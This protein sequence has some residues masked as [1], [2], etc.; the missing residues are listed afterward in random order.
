MLNEQI[1]DGGIPWKNRSRQKRCHDVKSGWNSI[2][3][4]EIFNFDSLD[5]GRWLKEFKTR[6]NCMPWTLCLS[7]FPRS[8]VP[9]YLVY[10]GIRGQWTCLMHKTNLYLNLKHEDPCDHTNKCL[11]RTFISPFLCK[12]Y[13]YFSIS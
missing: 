13:I 8:S 1:M 3:K 7:H 4:K 5:E 6:L 12:S 10:I 9:V 2:K 11:N